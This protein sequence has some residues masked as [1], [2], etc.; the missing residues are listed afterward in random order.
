MNIVKNQ[1]QKFGCIRPLNPRNRA[2]FQ[3]KTKQAITGKYEDRYLI[4]C[5]GNCNYAKLLLF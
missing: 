4:W 5:M 1:S 3:I 2:I